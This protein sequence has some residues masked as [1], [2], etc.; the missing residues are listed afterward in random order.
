MATP[1]RALN[2][3]S[4]PPLNLNYHSI[5]NSLLPFLLTALLLSNLSS[6]NLLLSALLF[7]ITAAL[8]FSSRPRPVYLIDH[9]C[10]KPP[11]WC[12]VPNAA[13]LEHSRTIL[14]DELAEF[15]MRVLE[16]SGLGEETSLPPPAH[17]LPPVTSLSG[18]HDEAELIVF[19][20][21]DELLSK[22]GVNPKDINVLVV[23]CNSFAPVPSLTSMIINRYKLGSD[24]RSYNLSGMGCSASPISIGLARDVLRVRP[25]STALVFSTEIVVSP[26]WYTGTRKSML[27]PNCLFRMGGVAV[28]LSNRGRHHGD[29]KYR[30]HYVV[31]THTGADDKAHQCLYQMEDNEGRLGISL[32]KEVMPISGEALKEHLMV[33][34]QL[35]LPWWEQLLFVGT[36]LGRKF[37]NPKWKIYV[38]Q[39]RKAFEHI[40]VHAGGRAVIDE[41]QMNLGLS[42]EQVE[43]SRMT[44]HRFGNTSSSSVWYELSYME[45]KGRMKKGDRVWQLGL[46]S[47]FKCNSSVWECM[48][49]IEKDQGPW[50][51]CIDRYP[52]EVPEV[53][54]F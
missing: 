13:F 44:L 26:A 42:S 53:L 25:E 50:S 17:Y 35:V 45:A 4:S 38:P 3:S 36:L 30:L 20:A 40:C 52:V 19:T 48:K 28:L 32:S 12:R 27:I 2:F 23:N 41:V 24:V 22:T 34:G 29:A 8:Y 21:V 51:G 49:N 14:G 5:L 33:L 11:E 43:A 7:L 9:A 54:K 6:S 47:G 1:N 46:G 18:S 31:R 37:I 15:Q 39:F 10:F 16:R